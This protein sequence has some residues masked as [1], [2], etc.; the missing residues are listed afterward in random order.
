MF[1]S[2]HWR[3]M[4]FSRSSTIAS[5][6]CGWARRRQPRPW[7]RPGRPPARRRSARPLRS[8]EPR[9]A[10]G[11]LPRRRL[12]RDRAPPRRGR[13]RWLGCAAPHGRHSGRP[14]LACAATAGSAARV[15]R[16][17]SALAASALEPKNGGS[18]AR[19][20]S[21][22]VSVGSPPGSAASAASD[23]VRL[24][25]RRQK[26]Q[27]IACPSAVRAAGAAAGLRR[28]RRAAAA[29]ARARPPGSASSRPS[30]CAPSR[31]TLRRAGVAP[32]RRSARSSPA[33]PASG[34]ADRARQ[35]SRQAARA[36]AALAPCGLGLARLG[37]MRRGV[38]GQGVGRLLRQALADRR[39]DISPGCR[40]PDR[41]C[42]FPNPTLSPHAPSR[43]PAGREPRPTIA[44][45]APAP[46]MGAGHAHCLSQAPIRG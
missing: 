12:R 3:S 45:P 24:R 1:S 19:S 14:R 34:G 33:S 11:Q 36:S 16:R 39:Q 31:A 44:L 22:R 42:S 29:A 26:P 37:G 23:A 40:P 2:S 35:P 21:G 25:A 17:L 7:A 5:S 10:A 18:A 43:R 32:R 9:R 46:H 20:T 27:R 30:R 41:A 13:A 38:L 28:A 4:G 6:A 15:D 8:G